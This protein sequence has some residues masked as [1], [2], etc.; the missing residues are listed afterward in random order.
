MTAA[1]VAT[2]LLGMVDGSAQPHEHYKLVHTIC[3]QLIGPCMQRVRFN[4]QLF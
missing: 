3:M 1:V 2:Y 4:S